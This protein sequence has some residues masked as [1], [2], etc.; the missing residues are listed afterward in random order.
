MERTCED[1]M[2][3]T[4]TPM[5]LKLRREHVEFNIYVNLLTQRFRTL[6]QTT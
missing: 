4:I 3:W 2:L 5:N 6:K 1:A